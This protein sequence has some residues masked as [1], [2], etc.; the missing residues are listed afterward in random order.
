M[1][2]QGA[3]RPVGRPPKAITDA[4]RNIAEKVLSSIDEIAEWTKLAKQD[5]DLKLKFEV[6]RYLTDRRDGR[7]AQAIEHKGEIKLILDL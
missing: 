7:A 5:E 1:A 6:M 2:K 3:V 4:K